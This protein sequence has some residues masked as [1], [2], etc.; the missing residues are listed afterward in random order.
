MQIELRG[1]GLFPI[2]LENWQSALEIAE[3][4][5][6]WPC[7]TVAMDYGAPPWCEDPDEVDEFERTGY[8]SRNSQLVTDSDARGL[9]RA[10]RTALTGWDKALVSDPEQRG[11]VQALAAFCEKGGFRIY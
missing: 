6:W 3:G 11:R 7:G 2:K 1:T 8:F 10:L 5:G 9:A 4:Y